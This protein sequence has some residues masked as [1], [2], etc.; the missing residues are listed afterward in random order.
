[1][2]DFVGGHA[3]SLKSYNLEIESM[4]DKCCPTVPCV[5]LKKKSAESVVC[6]IFI[7]HILSLYLAI[8][9]FAHPIP[10]ALC[11]TVG[12]VVQITAECADWYYGRSK[13]KGTCGIFPKSYAHI[14]QKSTTTDN[15]VQE[16][17]NVLREWGH[18]WKYLY[19]VRTKLSIQTAR[20]YF[21]EE[22]ERENTGIT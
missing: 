1:M 9:N 14:L 21:W 18:H 3:S 20:I 16:I 8:H 12:E 4:F 15:L 5:I 22:R 17:T 6:P 2:F 13:F 19:V 11:L 10:H 7:F